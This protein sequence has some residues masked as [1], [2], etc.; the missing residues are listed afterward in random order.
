MIKLISIFFLLSSLSSFAQIQQRRPAPAPDYGRGP[1]T[2]ISDLQYRVRTL[3]A[4]VQEL[5]YQLRELQNQGPRGPRG[6]QR[7]EPRIINVC[8]LKTNFDGTFIGKSVSRLEAETIARNECERARASFC[9]S[10]QV[11]CEEVRE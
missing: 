8:V 7:P 1:G 5:Q 6:P 2:E 3:E 9:G 4:V 10:T 11:K